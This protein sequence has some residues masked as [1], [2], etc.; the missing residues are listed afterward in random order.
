APTGPRRST[1]A[2]PRPRATSAPTRPRATSAPTRLRRSSR[3][4]PRPTPSRQTNSCTTTVPTRPHR[5]IPTPSR[6][7]DSCTTTVT[8]KTAPRHP[9]AFAANRLVHHCPRSHATTALFS[10]SF[11]SSRVS[12]TSGAR[13]GERLRTLSLSLLTHNHP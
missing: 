9:Y 1:R 11:C 12:R 8:T 4:P 10:S 3:A 13:A 6:Q 2:P 5:G 7:T